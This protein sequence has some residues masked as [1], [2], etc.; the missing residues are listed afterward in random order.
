MSPLDELRKINPDDLEPPTLTA[1]E[2]VQVLHAKSA[3]R[4]ADAFHILTVFCGVCL[5][6]MV[7]SFFAFLMLAAWY[8]RHPSVD[9]AI[10]TTIFGAFATMVGVLFGIS[11]KKALT[12]GVDAIMNKPND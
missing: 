7:M 1:S 3:L 9:T 10:V 8:E 12:R 6:V 5:C 11:Q 2:Y 4:Q